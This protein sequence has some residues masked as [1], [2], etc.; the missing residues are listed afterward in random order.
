M[1]LFGGPEEEQAHQEILAA[2]GAG[3][4]RNVRSANLRQT[5]ALLKHCH[6]F[7]SVD[8]ALMH[9]AAAMKVPNQVVIEAPTLNQTNLPWLT[10]YRVVRNPMVNGRNLEYY[11]YDGGPIKGSREHL[12]ACM[13]SVKVE[14]VYDAVREAVAS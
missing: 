6:A 14:D 9:L 12:L 8:T 1:L 2:V 11:R 13:A 10:R 4:V 7:L 5:A 3:A